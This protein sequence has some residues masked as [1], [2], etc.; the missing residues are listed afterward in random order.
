M[1]ESVLPPDAS[2]EESR[3]RNKRPA[4]PARSWLFELPIVVIVALV[5]SLLL[6]TFLVQAFWI[7]SGSM[8]QTLDVG[9]RV[10]V[11]KVTGH[12]R[13]VHR[14][15]IVVFRDPGGWL[16]EPTQRTVGLRGAVKRG[17]S[18]VGLAPDASGDD[19]I[20]RVIGLPGDRVV[21][22]DDGGRVT[23]NGVALTEPYLFPGNAPSEIPF[24]VTVP[25]GDVWVMGDHRASSQDSRAHLDD[26]RGGMVPMDNVV[27]RAFVTVW[28]MSRFGTI[29]RPPTFSQ[30]EL[31]AR[32]R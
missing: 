2:Q 31:D 19:L 12:V 10:L 1:S 6:K 24:D 27:G 7:P 13:D 20:K 26:T 30:P 21:C 32:G 9:D 18:F 3:S 11:E 22:C 8:E 25:A 5:V 14:G 28:P 29:G 4:S 15:D 17:L 16:S 23:V